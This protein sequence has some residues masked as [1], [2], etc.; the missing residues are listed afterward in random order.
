VHICVEASM[1]QVQRVDL[2]LV[3]SSDGGEVRGDGRAFRCLRVAGNIT[4]LCQ[5]CTAGMWDSWGLSY[6]VL[7]PHAHPPRCQAGVL[8]LQKEGRVH[9][10]KGMV[11]P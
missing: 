5:G 9:L 8:R 3:G 7:L 10:G 11:A 6:K 4:R 1:R 2:V